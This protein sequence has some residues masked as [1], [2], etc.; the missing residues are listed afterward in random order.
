MRNSWC[1]QG[2]PTRDGFLACLCCDVE[3]V[4]DVGNMARFL[5]SLL[6]C[7]SLPPVPSCLKPLPL[8]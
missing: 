2:P 3:L 6:L 4:R 8:I 5:F 1:E 7:H